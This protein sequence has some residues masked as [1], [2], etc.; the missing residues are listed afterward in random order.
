M[1][2]SDDEAILVNSNFFAV[3]WTNCVVIGLLLG[4]TGCNRGPQLTPVS[5]TV[6]LDGKPIG[7]AGVM[8]QPVAGGPAA[9]G[10]TDESGQFTLTTDPFGPGAVLGE[11]RVTVTKSTVLGIEFGES[12]DEEAG[13]PMNVEVQ[14]AVPTRYAR[15]ETSGLTQNVRQA[16]SNGYD[17]TL[18][19]SP[20]P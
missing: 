8:F 17:L 1:P 19:T 16:Q 18:T 10:V 9:S 11:H 14:D 13:P 7:G 4:A 15:P 6:I 12:G 20:A 2:N 3:H 5:G